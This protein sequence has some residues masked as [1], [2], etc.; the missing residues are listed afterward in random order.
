MGLIL[1]P[2]SNSAQRAASGYG[3]TTASKANRRRQR[4][5][6]APRFHTQQIQQGP[7][8]LFAGG[9]PIADYRVPTRLTLFDQEPTCFPQAPGM[10]TQ[11]CIVSA[12]RTQGTV[13]PA[14]DKTENS[15]TVLERNVQRIKNFANPAA[16]SSRPSLGIQR[17]GPVK[18][19]ASKFHCHPENV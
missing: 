7:T 3:A 10:T 2:H 4:T 5:A 17:A 6:D 16:Y 15:I 14:L 9:T 1:T 12:S 13:Q 18:G 8:F 11:G 19:A